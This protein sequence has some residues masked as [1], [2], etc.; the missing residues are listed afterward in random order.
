MMNK[1]FITLLVS[2]LL[3]LCVTVGGSLAFLI[4]TTKPVE[5]IFTPSKIT[6]TVVEELKDGVKESVKIK[7]TGDTTAFIRAYVI[8]TWQN[9]QGEVYGAAP[10]KGTDYTISDLGS[11]WFEA[12][13][14]YYHK[15]PV[16]KGQSTG[17]MFKEITAVAE[18]FPEG[19]TLHVE[20]IG[21]GI[22]SVP[23]EAVESAW[24]AVEVKDG[25]LN[26]K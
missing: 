8:V 5:N 13:G 11:G 1:K 6:T 10:V 17:V 20:I 16:E 21:S 22:Q 24:P 9:E 4:D 26:A 2:L 7:N 18:N 12:D 25:M 3:V 15:A 23:D 19:Y 14:F